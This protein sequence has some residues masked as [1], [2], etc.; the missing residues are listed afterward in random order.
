MDGVSYSCAVHYM[1][2][3][4]ARI[5]KDH[6]AV[7]LIIMSP[8]P[9]THKRVGREVRNFGSAVWDRDKQKAVLPGTYAEFTQS[10]AIKNR[11]LSTGNKL[12]P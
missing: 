4:K 12:K 8:D 11:L 1:M 5:F 6:R 10:A 9:S 2:A 7:E 3:E